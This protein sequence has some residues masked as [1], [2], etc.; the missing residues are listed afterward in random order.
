MALTGCAGGAVTSGTAAAPPAAAHPRDILVSGM[1]T[2]ATA[3]RVLGELEAFDGPAVTIRLD[4]P[5]GDVSAALQI[6]ER[7]RSGGWGV[8]TSVADGSR[9]MSACTLI[10]AA[11]DD[12]V[13]GPRARF[14][15]HAP[16]YV[17]R[18][19]LPGPIVDLIEAVTRRGIANTYAAVAPD[20]ARHLAEPGVDALNSRRGLA[21]S[22]AQLA[23]RGDGFVTGIERPAAL[24]PLVAVAEAD[25]VNPRPS[26][27]PP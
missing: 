24:A 11:G 27:A 6:H 14:Q 23:E 4:S 12:R 16:R 8:V 19:P 1:I 10:F 2:Q 21:L 7:L 22:G 9:C 15:F 17:G 18:M 26:P 3:D 5:G 25:A 20:F 13:A